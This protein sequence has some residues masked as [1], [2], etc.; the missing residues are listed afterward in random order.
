MSTFFLQ[1]TFFKNLTSVFSKSL[2][3]RKKV[4]MSTFFLQVTFFQKSYIR[5]FQKSY[6]QK[7]SGHVHFFSTGHFFPKILHPEKKWTCPLFFYRSLFS[8]NLTS[9]KKVD[10]STFFLNVIFSKNLT[11]VFFKKSYIQKKSG[12]VHFFSTGHFF[13]KILHPEKK[14]TCPLFFYRSLFSKNLT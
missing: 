2:T 7:K 11:S 1:V 4:D 12:H 10:M 5:F 6:I 14:W 13:P 3:S 9:R 8:K